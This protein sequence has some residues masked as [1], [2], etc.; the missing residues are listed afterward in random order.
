MEHGAFLLGR[1]GLGVGVVAADVIGA[2]SQA[3]NEKEREYRGE[4]KD[5]VREVWEAAMMAGRGPGV[6]KITP[7]GPSFSFFLLIFRKEVV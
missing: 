7:I 6:V 2:E 4:A 1:A 5:H 3:G